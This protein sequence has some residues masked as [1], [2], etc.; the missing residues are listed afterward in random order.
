[1]FG[2]RSRDEIADLPQ[3]PVMAGLSVPVTRRAAAPYQITSERL[4][5]AKLGGTWSGRRR[6]LQVPKR[7]KWLKYFALPVLR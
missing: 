7:A 1:M 3:G 6:W 2:V 4:A 5:R